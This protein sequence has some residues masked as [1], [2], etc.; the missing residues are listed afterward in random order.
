MDSGPTVDRHVDRVSIVSRPSL[1]RVS[2]D[3]RSRMP[4]VHMIR[5]SGSQNTHWFVMPCHACHTSFLPE[6]TLFP[7][8]LFDFL[9]FRPQ[10]SLPDLLDL[11]VTHARVSLSSSSSNK[12]TDV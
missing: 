9:S 4:L 2:I 6:Q 1:D 5:G 12:A 3:P 8:K 10:I 11:T 7:V